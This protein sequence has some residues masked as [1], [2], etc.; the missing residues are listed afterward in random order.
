MTAPALFT[1]YRP[2]ALAIAKEWYLPG[3]D[4]DDVRQEALIALWEAARS[5]KPEMGPPFPVFARLLINRRLASTLRAA[6]RGKQLVLTDAVR[7]YDTPVMDACTA[8]IQR[9]RVRQIVHVAAGLKGLEREALRRILA[10]KP[11]AS[12]SEDNARA[13][14]RV[15]M[16]A[17]A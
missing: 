12:K 4:Q 8:V 3:G 11:L 5:Y 9:E 2:I 15:K 10:D 14:V 16:K 13:R 17:A 1:K 6:L 7:D